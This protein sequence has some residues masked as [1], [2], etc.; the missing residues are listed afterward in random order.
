[1]VINDEELRRSTRMK[2]KKNIKEISTTDVY[3]T[4][5]EEEVNDTKMHVEARELLGLEPEFEIIGDPDG[6]YNVARNRH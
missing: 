2:E 4:L 1:M 6:E 5:T 3:V